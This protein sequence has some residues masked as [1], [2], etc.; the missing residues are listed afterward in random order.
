V[1]HE[2]V[3]GEL[4]NSRIAFE[5]A[6]ACLLFLRTTWIAGLCRCGL[7]CGVL[8]NSPAVKW[9]QF[10][11]EMIGTTHQPPLWRNP[12]DPGRYVE[13]T[14]DYSWCARNY[15][16]CSLN[17]PI[18]HLGLL[19]VEFTLSTIVFPETDGSVDGAAPVANIHVLVKAEPGPW[20]WEIISL[21]TVSK[22]VKQSFND[23]E[24]I[25]KAVEHCLTGS[26]PSSPSDAEWETHLRG[27]YFKV[28]K[29]YAL[30]TY[31][32]FLLLTWSVLGIY[33]ISG[34]AAAPFYFEQT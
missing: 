3:L 22:L 33:T 12:H 4:S 13:G 18:R 8:S 7:R 17:K 19:L 23:N 11:L 28:V 24:H 10:G 32:V 30:P 1:N 29:P 31:L 21:K 16:W 9:H 2:L 27:F 20:R 25:A 34:L 6:Q 15:H 14:L 26:F 5:L